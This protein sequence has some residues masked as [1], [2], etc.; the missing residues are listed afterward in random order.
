[1]PEPQKVSVVGGGSFG[2]TIAHVLAEGGNDVLLYVRNEDTVKEINERHKNARYFED[3]TLHKG[4]RATSSF[5]KAMKHSMLVFAMVP[6]KA[7]RSVMRELA[8]FATAEHM[9][10]HGTKGLE[11]ETFKTMTQLIR[12][13]T[14]VR[15]VGAIAGPNLAREILAGLPAATV[16]GSKFDEVVARVRAVLMTPRFLVYGNRDL[17]GVELGGTLKNVL[18]IG[19]GIIDGGSFGAN[20]KSLLITRGLAEM[21]RFGTHMGASAQ[22]FSGLSGIGDIIA[23]CTSP[24]SR[25]YQVGFRLG[26]GEA[27]ADIRKSLT[28]TVEGIDTT[29]ALYR[30]AE[31]ERIKINLTRGLYHLLFEDLPIADVQKMVMQPSA[32]YE[33]DSPAG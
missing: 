24:L 14:C 4:V 3:L 9:I 19:A 15:R 28:Q 27:L 1:M 29:A 30:Y 8:P 10:V 25:N 7:F 13:E 31:K 12:E 32:V 21:M 33:V 17:L 6:S 18:A 5:E 2:T 22:T 23:T 26:K 11:R 16:V 20:A